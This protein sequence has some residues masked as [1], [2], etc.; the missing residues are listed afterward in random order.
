MDVAVSVDADVW[1]AIADHQSDECAH[2]TN[3]HLATEQLQYSY[4]AFSKPP[5]PSP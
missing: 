1:L 2:M 3:H 4:Q 5:S